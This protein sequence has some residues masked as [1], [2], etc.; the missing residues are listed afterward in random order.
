[1]DCADEQEGPAQTSAFCE[2][3]V[4]CAARLTRGQCAL[5][6]RL[7][8]IESDENCKPRLITGDKSPFHSK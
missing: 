4:R 1:M 3:L 7:S 5:P 6:K 8:R 2:R